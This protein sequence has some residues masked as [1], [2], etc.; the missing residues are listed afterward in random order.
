MPNTHNMFNDHT[1]FLPEANEV[2]VPYNGGSVYQNG[3]PTYTKYSTFLPP[4]S[5]PSETYH[6]PYLYSYDNRS[7]GNHIRYSEGPSQNRNSR[8][9]FSNNAKSNDII[10][11]DWRKSALELQFA[12]SKARVS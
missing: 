6:N 3:G 2:Y 10:K 8:N 7:G 9:E 5:L 1:R 11:S 12:F 4:S